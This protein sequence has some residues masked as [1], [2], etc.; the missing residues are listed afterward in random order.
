MM[1]KLNFIFLC[2]LLIGCW[3]VSNAQ[4]FDLVLAEKLQ[5]KLDSLKTIYNIKGI[6]ASVLLPDQGLWKG[7]TGISIGGVPIQSDMEFGIGSN[8]KLFTAATLLRLAENNIIN[9]DDS[10]HEWLPNFVNID[11][12]ITIRQLLNH[13]SG[14]ADYNNIAGYPDSILSNPNRIFTPKELIKWVGAPLFVAGTSWDYSN[15]NY[16]VAGM[17]AESATGKNIA[18]LIREHILNPLQLDSTFFDVQE[19]VQ[20]TIA[21]PW[22]MGMNINAIPRISLN[23]AAY[24]AGAMYSTSSEMTQWYQK[25]MS[26]QVLN[27][28]SYSQM[29]TFVG[30][31][32]YGFG[33]TRIVVG[34]RTCFAH[35]GSIRG[36]SSFMLFDTTTKA[37]ICV[38]MNSNPSPARLVGEQL[39]LT[40]AS[41]PLSVPETFISTSLIEIYP[42][43]TNT[44]LFFKTI[45]NNASQYQITN[46]LGQVMQKENVQENNIDVSNLPNGIYFIRFTNN[47]NETWLSKF[48]KQ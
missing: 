15:T 14:L 44:T 29:T 1:K 19:T 32:N 39:L 45:N 26:G 34:G 20:G 2:H 33:L 6:S 7:T 22:Q 37:I 17:I 11:S 12:N 3:H 27:P 42:N 35:G 21:N 9:I 18:Q 25:L 41:F 8:T 30:S 5:T 13:T 36:Y 47:K 48:I 28:N 46:T 24:S 16:L 31:G 40:L 10:L 43:P 38:L 4:V 23:S